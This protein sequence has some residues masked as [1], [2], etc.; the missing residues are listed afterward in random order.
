MEPSAKVAR[1]L[2]VANLGI[3]LT[4][5]AG[6]CVWGNRDRVINVRPGLLFGIFAMNPAHALMHLAAG[7]AGVP[8]WDS[9]EGALRYLRFHA[10]FFGPLAAMAWP[11]VLGPGRIHMVMG[12]ALDPPGNVVHTA[13]A[14]TGLYHS[15]RGR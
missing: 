12:M 5:L 8:A 10:A 2:T 9:P 6:P 11:K 4:G 15:L 13:W 7:V 3:G 1:A 14:A